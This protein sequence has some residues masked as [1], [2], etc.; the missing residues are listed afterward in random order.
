MP[1]RLS[2]AEVKKCG[3]PSI[4]KFWE[5]LLRRIYIMKTQDKLYKTSTTTLNALQLTIWSY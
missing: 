3:L 2:K 4:A 1:P 5:V